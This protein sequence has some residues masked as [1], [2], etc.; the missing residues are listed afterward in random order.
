MTTSARSPMWGAPGERQ[1]REQRDEEHGEGREGQRPAQLVELRAEREVHY[2]G[3]GRERNREQ[4][5]VT[6]QHLRRPAVDG[7]LPVGIPVLGDE[8]VARVRGPRVTV[9]RPGRQPVTAAR[10]GLGAGI[11]FRGWGV[12]D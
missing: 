1:G 9:I 12:T 7:G 11:S 6:P 5:V 8:Q 3:A 4:A 10:D 2:L